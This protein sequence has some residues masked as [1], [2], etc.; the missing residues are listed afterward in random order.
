[1]KWLRPAL[2]FVL[3]FPLGVAAQP[4][5]LDDYVR[6]RRSLEAAR[7]DAARTALERQAGAALDTLLARGPA[8][9]RAS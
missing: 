3:L 6:M 5:A 1:M 4:V 8:G 2:C 9:A 7:D